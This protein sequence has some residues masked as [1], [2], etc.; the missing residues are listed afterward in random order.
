MKILLLGPSGQVG[1]ELCRA[2]EPLGEISAFDYPEVDL[3]RPNSLSALV[4]SIAPQVIVNAAAYTAVDRAESEPEVAELI[5]ARAVGV[6]AAEAASIG[7]WLVHYSTDYVFA[8][9]GCTPWVESDE[10]VP[11]N[12]YG[13]SKLGGDELIMRSGC[14]HLIL[15]TSWVFAARGKNFVRTILRLAAERDELRVVNDQYGVPTSADFL[16][17]ATAHTLTHA[18]R[19]GDECSGLF[20]AAPAGEATWQ[21][22]ACAVVESALRMGASL[23]VDPSRVKGIPSTEY[24]FSAKR[25]LNSRLNTSRLQSTFGLHCP[26]WRF[27]LDRVVGELVQLGSC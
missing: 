21:S 19:R 24:N 4:R 14:R 6:L 12:A 13:R 3:A 8:G 16:A 25:P 23:T 27:S 15:R 2:L 9:T 18:L 5:N 7:A 26:D 17:D 11:V 20:H 22:V 1:H 10:A